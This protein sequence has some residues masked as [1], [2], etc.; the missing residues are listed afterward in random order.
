[1][2]WDYNENSYVKV[3]GSDTVYFE[4]QIDEIN[5]ENGRQDTTSSKVGEG[6][7]GLSSV[8]YINSTLD[9]V[10]VPHID[11]PG[12]MVPPNPNE[13]IIGLKPN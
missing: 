3:S 5:I 7:A 12:N 9:N 4:E 11:V 2:V 6:G 8:S 1:M 10:K 13:N